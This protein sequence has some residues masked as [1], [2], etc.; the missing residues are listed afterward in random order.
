MYEAKRTNFA[1]FVIQGSQCVRIKI[2]E[3]SNDEM[4]GR[5]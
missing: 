1:T 4:N 3:M 2:Q 5:K